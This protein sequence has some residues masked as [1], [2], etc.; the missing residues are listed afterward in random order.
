MC[1]IGQSL[2]LD[3]AVKICEHCVKTASDYGRLRSSDPLLIKHE[4]RQ[5]SVKTPRRALDAPGHHWERDRSPG[6]GL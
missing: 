2:I 3:S 5:P 1:E 4:I 6:P